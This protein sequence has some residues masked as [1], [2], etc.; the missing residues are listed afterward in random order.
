MLR[1]AMCGRRSENGMSTSTLMVVLLATI[2]V[3]VMACKN[4]NIS[5]HNSKVTQQMIF[6]QARTKRFK[7]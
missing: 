5:E 1:V 4:Q 2:Q 3:H 6:M 7:F